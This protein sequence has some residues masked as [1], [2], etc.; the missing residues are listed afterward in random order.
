MFDSSVQPI[1]SLLNSKKFAKKAKI[2]FDKFF[3]NTYPAFLDLFRNYKYLSF[4]FS[5]SKI[6]VEL[7]SKKIVKEESDESDSKNND[8]DHDDSGLNGI[9]RKRPNSDVPEIPPKGI[10]S[11]GLFKS[12]LA[13]SELSPLKISPTKRS[14]KTVS[15]NFHK[16]CNCSTTLHSLEIR[17]LC[18][19]K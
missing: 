16:K 3:E 8:L 10:F 5:P 15:Q 14:K 12:S 11:S 17:C 2:C 6:K 18:L 4:F 13:S 1:R 19:M 9:K 7:P